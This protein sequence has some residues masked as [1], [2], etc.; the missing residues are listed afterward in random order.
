MLMMIGA[1][2]LRGYTGF[3]WGGCATIMFCWAFFRLPETK[4]RTFEELDVLFAQKTPSRKFAKTEV[5]AF[6]VH[7]TDA[8]R[9]R[10][11]H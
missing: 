7:G 1:W 9:D 4:D 8:L 5:D 3:V 2:N 11:A 6:N 10:L